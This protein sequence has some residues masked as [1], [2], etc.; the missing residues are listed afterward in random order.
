MQRLVSFLF[1][2]SSILAEEERADVLS[3]IAFLLSC[4]CKCYVPLSHGS[5]GLI[6]V[7]DCGISWSYSLY[8]LVILSILQSQ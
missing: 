6:A 1:L 2:Q 5:T 4:G 8:V 3:L 7:C